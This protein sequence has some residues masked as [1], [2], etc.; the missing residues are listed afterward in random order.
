[1]S[2]AGCLFQRHFATALLQIPVLHY[3]LHVPQRQDRNITYQVYYL[4]VNPQLRDGYDPVNFSL[5]GFHNHRYPSS[6]ANLHL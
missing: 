2:L 5:L 6:E 3:R 4:R 1:M